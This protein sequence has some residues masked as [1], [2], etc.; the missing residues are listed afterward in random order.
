MPVRRI[1]KSA[2]ASLLAASIGVV[3]TLGGPNSAY[4]AGPAG[5]SGKGVAGGALLGGELGTMALG[6]AGV[7]SGW[8]YY[9]L[10]GLGAAGGGVAGYFIEQ[11]TATTPEIATAMLAGGMALFIPSIVI[12]LNATSYQPSTP[13]APEEEDEQLPMGGAAPAGPS[14]N[15]QLHAPARTVASLVDLSSSEV[16]IGVPSPEVRPL[17][18]RREI[19]EFGLKQ[20]EEFRVPILSATF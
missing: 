12:S 17:Y 13:S 5:N 15:M 6:V 8:P 20:T 18:T 14:A 2:T 9:L 1:H 11:N 7:E 3:A 19:A 4:A 10:G 16:K